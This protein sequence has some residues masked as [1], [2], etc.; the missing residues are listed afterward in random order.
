MLL[1]APG[2][3][4]WLTIKY[5]PTEAYRFKR[6]LKKWEADFNRLPSRFGNLLGN[7]SPRYLRGQSRRSGRMPRLHSH[8]PQGLRTHSY[9]GQTPSGSWMKWKTGRSGDTTLQDDLVGSSRD[10]VAPGQVW[11]ALEADWFARR[12]GSS[13]RRS[14][15]QFSIPAPPN[16]AAASRCGGGALVRRFPGAG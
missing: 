5:L 15:N 13:L 7:L 3:T 1:I 14:T 16:Q 4:C 11:L 2:M 9:F 8:L 6:L 12:L 10:L